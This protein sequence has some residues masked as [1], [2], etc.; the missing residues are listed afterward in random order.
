MA[1]GE[2]GGGTART[3]EALIDMALK[4]LDGLDAVVE[5]KFATIDPSNP[6]PPP[7]PHRE[8]SALRGSAWKRKASLQARR[9]LSGRLSPSERS[10]ASRRMTAC[11]LKS[12]E[13]Y[14]C[15][16]GSPGSGRFSPYH[17]LNRLAL[18]AL[19]K[20]SETTRDAAIELAQQCRRAAADG[21]A[22]SP[23]LWDAVNQPEALLIERLIDGGLGQPGDA[24]CTVF[25]EVAHAYADA[26]RNITV[27]PSQIDSMVTQMDLLSRFCDALSLVH[28]ND[29]ALARTAGRLIDLAQRLQPGRTP[30]DDR[31]AKP[32]AVASKR[33]Q[34][35]AARKRAA[36]P[37]NGN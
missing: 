21:F 15:A 10:V 13:S 8:R 32:A 3:A 14:Q 35:P 9:L 23:N 19:T 36:K 18:D 2:R 6:V 4:R 30:R 1:K 16:E 22:V 24:G 26:M 12:I 25:D 28:H 11:L 34:K 5:A 7:A 20:W 27:K 31:P 33:P 17:A 29:E 37:D